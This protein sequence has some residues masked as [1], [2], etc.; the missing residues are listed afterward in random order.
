MSFV[1][2]DGEFQL[3]SY[4]Y[5]PSATQAR[6][7]AH[8][9]Q[10]IP[11]SLYIKPVITMGTAGGSFNLTVGPPNNFQLGNVPNLQN[12]RIVLHLGKRATAVSGGISS[13]QSNS[14]SRT[15]NG[16]SSPAA[17]GGSWEFDSFSRNLRW[18]IPQLSVNSYTLSGTWN[19]EAASSHASKP[20][21]FVEVTFE[22][23]LANVSG[24]T[25]T[26]LKL[27]TERYSVYKGVRSQL[28]GRIEGRW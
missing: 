9:T 25:I 4:R 13:R 28:T 3:L 21:P 11:L 15:A 17:S 20:S 22:A 8:D 19:Y 5:V 27:D 26:N 7:G 16:S 1:P 23:A 24:T 18:T 6:R 2:P 12:V 10:A 14:S